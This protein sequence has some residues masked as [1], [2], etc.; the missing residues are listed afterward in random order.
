MHPD[1]TNENEKPEATIVAAVPKQNAMMI[2]AG[3]NALVQRTLGE[4][5]VAVMMAKQFPRD[6]IEAKEKLIND[7]CR[8]GLAAVSTYSYARGGTDITGPTIRFAE[9]AKNAWGNLQSGYRELTRSKGPDGVGFSEVEAFAWDTEN[10][11]R[12]S[13]TFIVR[14]WRDTKSG[15]YAL[16]EER[17][18]RELIA[19]QSKRLE[20][21]CILNSVDG[22]IIEAGLTQC[23]TT[24]TTKVQ[25]TPDRIKN[26]ATGFAEYGITIPQIEKRI[27]RRIEAINPALMISLTK[28]FNSMKDG[29]SKAED[30]FEPETAADG[31]EP[32]KGNEGVK[33]KLAKK[34]KKAGADPVTG[35]ILSPEPAPAPAP[36]PAAEEEDSEPPKLDTIEETKSAGKSLVLALKAAPKGVRSGVFVQ[37]HG[38]AIIDAIR[39]HGQGLLLKE[40][41]DCG[42]VIPE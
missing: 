13:T 24:L 31:K 9:A 34:A 17:D 5:Q 11:T 39:K 27:Q 7:C 37:A 38:P 40:I 6:K 2:S 42:I 14:H 20:R 15:G 32:A 18:I 12:E 28:I 41:T 26:L 21:T 29:M 36:A 4:V 33:E 10:N 25:V 19:N 30:W 22:D 23:N 1:Q 8:E 3:A 16:K 35:E